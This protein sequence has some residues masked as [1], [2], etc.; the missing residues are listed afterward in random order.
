M[1]ENILVPPLNIFTPLTPL[2]I[3]NVLSLNLF[4]PFEILDPL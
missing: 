4:A 1:P 3:I 2:G